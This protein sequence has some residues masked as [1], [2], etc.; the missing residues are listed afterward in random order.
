MRLVDHPLGGGYGFWVLRV[1]VL[2]IL[3]ALSIFPATMEMIEAIVHLAEHGEVGHDEHTAALGADEHGCTATFHLCGCHTA[4]S[5]NTP[6]PESPTVVGSVAYMTCR[7]PV[8]VVGLGAT[9]PPIRPP[10]A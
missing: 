1:R 10:I 6:L 7:D 8:D 3:L 9:A 2:A 5:V 4:N